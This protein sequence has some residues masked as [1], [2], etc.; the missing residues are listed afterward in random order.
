MV[1]PESALQLQRLLDMLKN[2]AL[3]TSGE[4]SQQASNEI[5]SRPVLGSRM[6]NPEISS[7]LHRL[8]ELLANK[9]VEGSIRWDE[10]LFD[11]LF[12][13]SVAKSTF[14]I[15]RGHRNVIDLFAF[16]I[17]DPRGALAARITTTDEQYPESIREAIR[18]L[19][20]I[21]SARASHLV[22]VLDQALDALEQ[23]SPSE[24]WRA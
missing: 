3:E 12:V 15:E 7:R 8:L 24:H 20:N 16:D 4:G 13:A 6:A 2:K 18:T 1:N 5:F 17:Y 19:W 9:T 21:V 11:Q 14:A 23:R 22:S 10:H